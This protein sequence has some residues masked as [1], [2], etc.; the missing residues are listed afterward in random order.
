MSKNKGQSIFEYSALAMLVVVGVIV[1][2]P[3][4][5]RSIGAHFKLWQESIDDPNDRM[6]INPSAFEA[7]GDVE[8]ACA[9]SHNF[10]S[11]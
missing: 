8:G 11:K 5:V 1:M 7:G 10:A 2:G 6:E 9:S 3:Y 4:I